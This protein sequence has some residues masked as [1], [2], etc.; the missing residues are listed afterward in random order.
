LHRHHHCYTSC[1]SGFDAV[2]TGA[3]NAACMSTSIPPVCDE[4][5]AAADSPGH[6]GALLTGS[7]RIDALY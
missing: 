3:T 6:A 5:F 2:K 1:C 4:K 7:F